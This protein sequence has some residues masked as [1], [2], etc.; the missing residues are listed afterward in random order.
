MQLGV[1]DM[2][3][4]AGFVLCPD[5]R[6]FVGLRL[7]VAIHTL[8]RRVQLPVRKPGVIELIIAAAQRLRRQ[9]HP[10]QPL[11]RQVKPVSLGIVQRPPIRLNVT[12][13]AGHLSAACDARFDII[14]RGLLC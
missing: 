11:V 12:I 5:N 13:Q 6:C 9:R 4:I 3:I 14:H 2:L 10:R 8:N 7:D 1:R